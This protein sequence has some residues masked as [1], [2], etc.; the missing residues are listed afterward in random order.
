M[1]KLFN[2]AYF[3]GPPL[4]PPALA[5][6]HVSGRYGLNV[7]SPSQHHSRLATHVLRSTDSMTLSSCNSFR[8][9]WAVMGARATQ[10]LPGLVWFGLVWF[11]LVWAK[12]AVAN[13]T[14]LTPQVFHLT[15]HIRPWNNSSEPV[16]EE[17]DLH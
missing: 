16:G 17:R 8:W 12:A 4:G 3:A 1:L 10:P 13:K 14:T 7:A 5:G 15:H 9:R 6:L 2:R 11:G